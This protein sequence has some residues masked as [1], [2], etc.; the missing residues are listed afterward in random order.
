M[1]FIKPFFDK[2]RKICKEGL[3]PKQL[4]LS[5]SIAL[6]VTVFPIFGLTTIVLTAIAIPLKINL[7]ITILL[8]Y[9]VEPL[10]LFLILPFIHVGSKLFNM[11]HALLT[12]TAI[13]ASY[14][15]DFFR[16]IKELSFELLCGFVGWFVLAVPV[17]VALYFLLKMILIF[18]MKPKAI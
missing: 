16:T 2:I 6:L 12:F 10:K 1:N 9:I 7:P 15:V 4:A 17:S 18:F 11:E 14:E 8:S 3:T 5:I 13:K